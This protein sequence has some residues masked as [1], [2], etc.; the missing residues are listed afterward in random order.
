MSFYW[1][2]PVERRAGHARAS[3][4]EQRTTVAR[5]ALALCKCGAGAGA[6]RRA[7]HPPPPLHNLLLPR[8]NEDSTNIEA[9]R[10]WDWSHGTSR[11]CGMKAP[12]SS[13]PSSSTK[14]LRYFRNFLALQPNINYMNAKLQLFAQDMEA[15]RWWLIIPK[16]APSSTSTPSFILGFIIQ[17]WFLPRSFLNVCFTNI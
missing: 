17:K 7:R 13:A 16:A 5:Q 9:I 14:S 2:D 1:Q 10:S 8:H 12:V 11:Q 4:G 3:R 15:E 6:V